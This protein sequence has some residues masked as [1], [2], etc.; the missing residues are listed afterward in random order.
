MHLF[1]NIYHPTEQQVFKLSIWVTFGLAVLGIALGLISGSQAIIFDGVF[2]AIDASMSVLSLFVV[3]LLSSDGSKRFQ[4]G[5][6]HLEPLVAAFNGSIL[7][8]LCI[9]AIVNAVRGLLEGGRV[10]SIDFAA[11]YSII[12]CLICFAAYRYEAY[13]NRRLKSELV[14]I[15]MQSFMM[16]AFIT[17]ALFVG[18]GLAWMVERL[19]FP[20]LRSY[21][22]SIVLLLLALG[23]LPIP[24]RIVSRA[25]R[26]VFLIAPEKMHRQVC[27][28]LNNVIQKYN[29]L[30]FE[31]YV[32]KTGRMNMVAIHILIPKDYVASMEFYDKVRA[33]IAQRLGPAFDLEEWLSI[34]FTSKANWM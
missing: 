19:G 28:V 25:M 20:A 1:M 13:V 21:A 33:D 27:D 14:R 15:D 7:V 30:S 31:S 29:F 2:A 34:S 5:Y 12:V 11:L 6:W 26:E 23:L 9:Y 16:S 17:I 8:L 22:D 32:T 10:V 4:Y 3:K 24:I 18:F